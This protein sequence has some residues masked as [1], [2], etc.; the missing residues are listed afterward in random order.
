MPCARSLAYDGGRSWV[1][2]PGHDGQAF[3]DGSTFPGQAQFK[4]MIVSGIL[5]AMGTIPY[6]TS[7]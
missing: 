4:Q 2:T 1:T 3:T 5:S 7:N 6:C